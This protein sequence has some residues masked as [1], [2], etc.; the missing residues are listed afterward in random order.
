MVSTR[1]SN[2]YSRLNTNSTLDVDE[3]CEAHSH[4]MSTRFRQFLRS[5]TPRSVTRF[6]FDSLGVF[7]AC[8]L[9]WEHFYTIQRSEGPSMYPTFS[10]RGDWLL[11]SR[12]HDRGRDIKVGDVVRFNH[13]SFR[14]INGAKRVLGMPGDFVCRDEQFSAD[15]GGEREMLQVG[16]NL[17][18]LCVFWGGWLMFVGPRRSCLPGRRQPA[19]V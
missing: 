2:N 11:I 1:R 3:T 10:V 16:H 13:P 19:V 14:G 6:S 12:R 17:L 15:A 8:I 9:I 18:L 7:C 5:V 4:K